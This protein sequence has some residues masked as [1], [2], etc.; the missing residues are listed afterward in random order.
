MLIECLQA[1]TNLF[2][3]Y[4]HE[5]PDIIPKVAC[6]QLKLDVNARY[7]SQ[8]RR[9]QSLEKA[10]ATKNTVKGLLDAKFISEAKYIEF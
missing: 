10:E 2:A 1:N 4:P 8:H 9:K 3:I 7:V 5:I 6:H